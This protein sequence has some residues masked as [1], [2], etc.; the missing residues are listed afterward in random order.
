MKLSKE[1][2]KHLEQK[3]LVNHTLTLEEVMMLHYKRHCRRMFPINNTVAID[4]WVVS[5]GSVIVM[6]NEVVVVCDPLDFHLVPPTGSLEVE[7]NKVGED[8]SG[9]LH[10]TT[11][12]ISQDKEHTR[13]KVVYYFDR[14]SREYSNR[15]EIIKNPSYGYRW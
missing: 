4:N 3:D 12:I 9:F 14:D 6:E 13:H 5:K 1:E 15:D 11:L 8:R 2:L 10:G 7:V